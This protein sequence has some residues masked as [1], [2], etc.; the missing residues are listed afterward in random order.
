MAIDELGAELITREQAVELL[1]QHGHM[2][3][4][5]KFLPE[6]NRMDPTMCFDDAVGIKAEYTT[7]EVMRW[8]GY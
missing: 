8:L 4:D 3:T 5:P 7:A 1:L 2:P 6:E